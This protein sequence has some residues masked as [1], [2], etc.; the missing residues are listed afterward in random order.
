MSNCK[1][2]FTIH[3]RLKSSGRNRNAGI[4]AGRKRG[5]PGIGGDFVKTSIEGDRLYSES[6]TGLNGTIGHLIAI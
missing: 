4:S 6:L 5:L 1:E 3:K 2:S